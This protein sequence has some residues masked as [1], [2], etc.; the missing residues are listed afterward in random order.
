MNKK[1]AI[2]GGGSAGLFCASTILEKSENVEID[3]YEKKNIIGKKILVSG[4]GKCNFTNEFIDGIHYNHEE[5]A[6]SILENFSL[7]D[8]LNY[9]SKNN[10][11]YYKDEEGRYYPI[12]NSS[13]SV[14]NSILED[15]RDKINIY[16]NEEVNE[17]SYDKNYIE[18]V[19]NNRKKRYDYVVVSSGNIASNLATLNE[20]NYLKKLDLN[21][22]KLNPSLCP[23]ITKTNLKKLNGQRYKALVKLYSEDEFLYEEKG[24]VLI[25]E[26]GFSGIV[27][28]QMSHFINKFK[29]EKYSL[30][31]DFLYDYSEDDI[32]RILF[33]ESK[34]EDILIGLISKKFVE[35]NFEKSLLLKKGKNLNK[36]EINNILKTLKNNRL[37]VDSLYDYKF[38]QVISGGINLDEIKENLELKKYENIFVCGEVIDINGECGGYNLQFA[39]SSAFVVGEKII[40][41]IKSC[42]E[43]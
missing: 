29:K 20:F 36:D 17:I 11:F 5:F 42:N 19:S 32:R 10:L 1:I 40:S 39:F 41:K 33:K 34:I 23:I 3:I 26:D 30:V 4:N 14:L 35:E 27:I 18:I 38:S 22:T 24:E 8:T 7:K 21:I 9:F 37:D 6:N 13:Y 31:F 28:F 16:F 2:I 43:L 12:S 25:K 15:I